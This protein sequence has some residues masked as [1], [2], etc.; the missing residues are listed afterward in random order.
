MNYDP[1]DPLAPLQRAC[2]IADKIIAEKKDQQRERLAKFVHEDVWAHWMKY[3]FSKCEDSLEVARDI[4]SGAVIPTELVT[5]WQRQL[6]AA[7]E[8]L[9]EDEKKS[10]RE[11]AD[12]LM[13]LL[14]E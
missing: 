6:R 5:R 14:E 10:D 12:K 3:L 13:K 11:L 7:Y 4:V 8:D 1:G 2:A 9:P